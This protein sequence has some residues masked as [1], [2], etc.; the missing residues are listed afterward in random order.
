MKSK[1]LYLSYALIAMGLI[2]FLVGLSLGGLV[3][4][5]YFPSV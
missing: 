5:S 1:W 3:G 2:V 4:F